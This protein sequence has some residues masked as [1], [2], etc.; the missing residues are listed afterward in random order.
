MPFD[1][2]TPFIYKANSLNKL[3]SFGLYRIIND[4]AVYA[5]FFCVGR[6]RTFAINAD[7]L[8]QE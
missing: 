4:K 3:S 6:G 1:P 7:E 2:S 8:E 5:R